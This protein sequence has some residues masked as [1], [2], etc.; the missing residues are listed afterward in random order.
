MREDYNKVISDRPKTNTNTMTIANN[1]MTDPSREGDI[2][3]D[4]KGTP[5][6]DWDMVDWDH[7]NIFA[8]YQACTR[9]SGPGQQVALYL[10]NR[11]G[12]TRMP[13]AKLRQVVS[14]PDNWKELLDRVS[15]YDP[16]STL[17]YTYVC[18][19]ISTPQTEEKL[20]HTCANVGDDSS[21]PYATR[22]LQASKGLRL[23][24]LGDV[25]SEALTDEGT[26]Y[27]FPGGLKLRT[28][29]TGRR[30]HLIGAEWCAKEEE[31][32]T[33]TP[34]VRLSGY[35]QVAPG[36]FKWVREDTVPAQEAERRRRIND[37]RSANDSRRDER[38]PAREL[39]RKVSVWSGEID[40]AEQ[41]AEENRDTYEV[42]C[43]DPIDRGGYTVFA[44]HGHACALVH[45]TG[46][47]L[48]SDLAKLLL[49]RMGLA[50]R[51]RGDWGVEARETLVRRLARCKRN[52]ICHINK[53]CALDEEIL[54]AATAIDIRRY[55]PP[56]RA[57][58]GLP[59]DGMF[60][61]AMLS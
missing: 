2:N 6:F 25:C 38:G 46:T 41:E 45:D 33:K 47:I 21:S 39:T 49:R 27:K 23:E 10:F 50:A 15:R 30:R 17:A 55:V 8:E 3:P 53:K 57:W 22:L 5:P 28:T 11:H 1:I 16:C 37:G 9:L 58:F 42:G 19:I 54:A 13:Y 40:P 32:T 24:L 48:G 4:A 35:V 7:P 59:S 52:Y 26:E 14:L 34:P 60:I 20:A 18:M 12:M 43:L 44:T 36:E 29:G 56:S 31:F 51:R 61:P